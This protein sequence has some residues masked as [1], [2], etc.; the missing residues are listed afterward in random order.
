M[1]DLSVPTDLVG[2]TADDAGAAHALS[3]A[4][5]WPHDL[6]DWK[7]M[8][9][10]AHGIGARTRD[11]GLAAVGLLFRHGERAATAG[12]IIVS[13]KH[14][15]LGL[16]RQVMAEILAQ[17]G[18]AR[19]LW[20]YATE[21]GLPL[22]RKLGFVEEGATLSFRGSWAGSGLPAGAAP[23]AVDER[24]RAGIEALD[25]EIFGA[26]RAGLLD[27]LRQNQGRA[28]VTGPLGSPTGFAMIRGVGR[29]CQ[30]GPVIASDDAEAFGL[31]GFLGQQAGQPLRIDVPES[32]EALCRDLQ[33][34]GLAPLP[35]EPLM[36]R[37]GTLPGDRTRLFAVASSAYG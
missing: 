7:T 20:L 27:R 16:G 17:A 3:V 35:R 9:E 6:R 22:Y 33:T 34:A 37:G 13:G 19:C 26:P 14:R 5:R 2:L 28:C 1:N 15:G 21:A 18:E 12:M 4:E 11:G 29:G 32:A 31:I 23:R 24:D 8:L 10:L 25:L 36:T 30:I